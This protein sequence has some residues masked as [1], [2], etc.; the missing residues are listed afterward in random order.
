MRSIVPTVLLLLAA[1]CGGS[2]ETPGVEHPP[3]APQTE[4]EKRGAAVFDAYA[5]AARRDDAAAA[6]RLLVGR[7]AR[8]HRCAGEPRFPARNRAA[9]ARVGAVQVRDPS[10]YG[11]ADLHLSAPLDPPGGI[12]SSLVM[13]LDA[14]RDGLTVLDV[15]AGSY[16]G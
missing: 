2:T 8:R 3:R 14:R 11:Q 7:A 12:G 4:E 5:D 16:P 9:A 13:F 6:C 10:N 15:F 1:G